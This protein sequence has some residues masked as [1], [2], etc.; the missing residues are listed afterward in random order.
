MEAWMDPREKEK[1][2]QHL[3]TD[4]VMLEWGSGG[5]T[6][7]FSA[8]VKKYYSIEHNLEWYNSV[9]STIQ[10]LGLE[11][12]DYNFIEPNITHSSF[13]GQSTYN[14]FQDYIDIV[15][16][17]DT[18]FDLVLIDGRARRLCAKKIIPYLNPDAIIFIH[19]YILRTPYWVVED[20]FDLIDGVTNTQQTIGVFKLKSPLPKKGYNLDLDTF[21]RLNPMPDNEARQ[22]KQTQLDNLR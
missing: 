2:T 15:D 14:Q 20:Y 7:E 5:S 8:Q 18:K 17:F 21:D 13:Q 11:N 3:S 6:I 19:D 9:S 10:S 1:I 22:I 16:K 4:K 12:I